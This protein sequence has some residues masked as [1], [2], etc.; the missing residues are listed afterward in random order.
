MI[1][2]IHSDLLN[3]TT[4]IIVHGCNAQ[5]KMG[6]GLAKSIR[7]KY[8]QVY[9]DYQKHCQEYK[10]RLLGSIVITPINPTLIIVSGITQE[11]YGRDPDIVYVNYDAVREVFSKV[12]RLAWDAWLPVKYP[13]IG[14]GL[15]NGDFEFIKNIIEMELRGVPDH[16][17]FIQE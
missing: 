14:A 5:G 8:P 3:E 17:L 15:A 2:T 7:D 1:N 10:E 4:G 16:M 12:S 9:I 13:A 11:Y 6:S